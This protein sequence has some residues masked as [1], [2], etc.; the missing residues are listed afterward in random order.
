MK[1]SLLI[2]SLCLLAS[3]FYFFGPLNSNI[4]FAATRTWS[5]S[6]STDMGKSTNYSGSGPLLTTDD[7]VFNNTSVINATATST[8]DVGS[9][10]IAST[11]SGAWNNAG[12]T[13]TVEDNTGF[14]DDG[15]TG[16]HNYGNGITLNGA[17]AILHIGHGVNGTITSSNCAITMNGTTAM[18][19]DDAKNTYF[20]SLNLGASSVVAASSTA[21]FQSATIPFAIGNNSN[22]TIN[23]GQTLNI[24]RTT[25]GDLFSAGT[26]Y[27]ITSTGQLY[28]MANANNITLSMPALIVSGNGSVWLSNNGTCTGVTMQFTGTQ[29]YTTGL[30]LSLNATSQFVYNFNNQSVSVGHLIIDPWTSPTTGSTIVNYTNSHISVTAYAPNHNYA[31]TENFGSSQWT[32]SGNWTFGSNHTINASTSLVTFTNTATIHNHG[33]SF[34]DVAINDAGAGKIITLSDN[35][36]AHNLNIISAKKLNASSTVTTLGGNL[37]I[38][39]S[40]TFYHLTMSSTTARTITVATGKTLTL[41]TLAASDLNGSSGGLNIWRSGTPSSQFYLNIPNPT[42]LTYQNPQDCSVNNAINAA[43]GTSVDGLNNVNFFVDNTAPTVTAFTMPSTA[44]SL[45]VSVSSLTGHDDISV[46]GYLITSAS[47]TPLLSNP[48]WSG[49]PQSSF[50]FSGAGVQKAYAWVKDEDGNISASASST[51]SI[52]L[53][54]ANVYYSVGSTTINML[55]GSPTITIANGA[56]V[57][58]L[59]QTGNIG[60]GDKVTYNGGSIAYISG[61][62]N[63][64]EMHWNLVTATGGTPANVSTVAVAAINRTFASLSAAVTGAIGVSYLNNSSLVA[65]NAILNIPCY[66]DGKADTAYANITGYTT[67]T[68]TYIKIYTPNS[69][70]TEVNQSQR[71]AGKWDN[72]KYRLEVTD[73]SAAIDIRTNYVRIIGLQLKQIN[74]AYTGYSRT[75][76]LDSLAG[77]GGYIVVDSNIVRGQI[78]GSPSGCVGIGNA[79]STANPTFIVTNNIVYDF[80]T[81]IGTGIYTNTGIGYYYNN[82]VYNV[83]S[84]YS[85]TAAST[86]FA[87][88]NIA[89]ADTTAFTGTYAASSTNNISDLAAQPP[90]SN[91]KNL[92]IV[93]FVDAANR[94]LHLSPLDITARLSGANLSTDPYYPFTNDIDGQ[95]RPINWDAGAD[96]VGV[97]IDLT[98][99]TIN[100]FTM[101]ATASSTIVNVTSFSA[102]DVDDAVNAY[103]IT[104]SSSTPALSN[105][106]WSVTPQTS[107]T[108][109]S[110]NGVQKAYAWARDNSGNISASAS[111]TVSVTAPI[112]NVYYS[113]GSTTPNMLTGS[114]TITIT[115]G[116]AVFSIAQTGNIGV[117]DKITYNGGS[118]AYISAKT[119]SDMMH[120]NL[121]TA[122]GGTPINVS[123][124]AVTAINR[125]FASL[126][127]AIVGAKGASYLNNAS[128]VTA[129]A[130]LNI[131]CYYDGKPDTVQ[132]SVINYTTATSTYINIYTPN[133]TSTQAN[134][135][136]RHNGRWNNSAYQL[137]VKG[138]ALAI[139]DNFVRITGLQINFIATSTSYQAGIS[140]GV[141]T[142]S[143]SAGVGGQIIIDSNIIRGQITG[144]PI[145]PRGISNWGSTAN[146][147]VKISNNIIYDINTGNNDGDG[148][149]SNGNT[150][151]LYNN[152]VYNANIAYAVQ[153]AGTFYFKNDIAQNSSVTSYSFW[154]TN[155]V[156]ASSIDN[157][158]DKA[159]QAPG[160]S[161]KNLATV[162]FV[163]AANKDFHLLS[164]DTVAR[165]S[166]INLS[167]DPDYAFTNDINGLTRP[168]TWDIGADQYV[169]SVPPT[170]TAFTMPATSS[171]LTINVNSFTASDDIGVVGYLIT[172]SSPTPSVTDSHWTVTRPATFTFTGGDGAKTAYAWAKDASGNISTSWSQSVT[173]TIDNTPPIIDYFTLPATSASTTVSIS[174]LSAHD[175]VGVISYLVT[176]YSYTPT[177]T[178]TNWSV[179]IPSTITFSGNG[180]KYAY[181]WVKDANNNIS[182]G[183]QAQVTINGPTATGTPTGIANNIYYVSSISTSTNWIAARNI[184]TPCTPTTAFAN[185]QAG[186]TVYFRGGFYGKPS[187]MANYNNFTNSGTA[188]AP[189]TYTAYPGEK[190]TII[191][192][193]YIN[194]V[195]WINFSGFTMFGSHPIPLTW[196]DMPYT[197]IDDP[198]VGDTNPFESWTT[199]G[200]KVTQKYSTYMNWFNGFTNHWDN[201][202]IV[203][204]SNNITISNNNLSSF[205]MGISMAG[206]S[207]N[208]NIENNYI[209]HC[210]SAISSWS[211]TPYKSFTFENS[212]ISG[213]HVSQILN[214][215]IS[216]RYG[217]KNILI[218]NNLADYN[219]INGIESDKNSQNVTIRNNVIK[220][221]GYYS[222]TMPSPGSSGISV[223]FGTENMIIEN[224]ISAYQ[225]DPTGVD[226]NGIIIDT[227][228]GTSSGVITVRNNLVYNNLR[229]IQITRSS[230][231]VLTNNT[232][233]NNNEGIGLGSQSQNPVANNTIANNILYN[234]RVYNAYFNTPLSS[235]AYIDNNLYYSSSSVPDVYEYV[236][237][238]KTYTTLAALRA[239]TG[240]ELHGLQADPLFVNPAANDFHLTWNSPAIGTATTTY[241]HLSDYDGNNIYGAPGIGAY[242][243]Q[244]P[245]TM[246]IDKVDIGAGAKIF[247]DGK[248][249]NATT[250]SSNLADLAITPG[251][252]SFSV[253]AS[254]TTIP[255]WLDISNI[256][257]WNKTG[258]Y[259]KHWTESSSII[260]D[261]PTIHTV[262]DLSPNTNYL[263]QVDS[264]TSTISCPNG[265]CRSNS[266]GKITFTYTGGYSTHQFD[267]SEGGDNTAPVV[268]QFTIL[269]TSNSLTVPIT[270][271][272]ATDNIGVV[273]YLVNESS[274]TPDI[275]D[276]HWSISTSSTYTFA[277]AGSKILYAWA[278][279]AGSNI[280][281]S[282]T[283]SVVITLPVVNNN[284]GSGGYT[285]TI[286]PGIPTNFVAATS[287]G[288]IILSWTNPTDNDLA[289]VKLYRK[290]NSA[291]TG[292]TDALAKLIYQGKNQI[293]TDATT[294]PGALYYYSLY[295]YDARPNYSLPNTIFVYLAA[296]PVIPTSTPLIIPPLS[297]TTTVNINPVVGSS[298]A[299]ITSLIGASS[300]TVN[301]VTATEAANLV[302]NA[303]MVVF[304]PAEK[305]NYLKLTA[306]AITPLSANEKMT[307]ADFI[308]SGTPTTLKLGAG[309][310]AGVISSFQSAFNRLPTS[311]L[312]WQ[313]VIKIGN[314]R[315][316]TQRSAIAEAKAKVN[317]KKIYLRQPNLANA[318]DSSAIAIMAYGLRPAQRN[319]AS[320]IAAAKSF[321]FA[322]HRAPTTAREW[323]IVR[324]IA[325]SGAKR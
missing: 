59:A 79:G 260:G 219:A 83:Y 211:A 322:Y 241:A 252:G 182:S 110:N 186:D 243:F 184:N 196:V 247:G 180:L 269:A 108:F 73:V 261:N 137:N 264:A 215:A 275:N 309:E 173:I 319:L 19:L 238:A 271:F 230:N 162:N 285:D 134:Q 308:H 172:Q 174:S 253:Y 245:N 291:P 129:N 86:V 112:L 297:A 223:G 92:A 306:L 44:S 284:T 148:F 176:E 41:T 278:K 178:N 187:A 170:I 97:G 166:G 312:D 65:A 36:T 66:Y 228:I 229:G 262:G 30:Y 4:A 251:S 302:Q 177:A 224:N 256:T 141:V 305:I 190:P 214:A 259:H 16:A 104:Q 132:A 210:Y 168:A 20:K 96:Q 82:T 318:H 193:V 175:N 48:N 157:I 287:T 51:V 151:Y 101:P 6:A 263:V 98:A 159:N 124:V 273:G 71:A 300:A 192:Y 109:S 125:T 207:K 56:A 267:I 280:S 105:L 153:T 114:P 123:T 39:T 290:T 160:T 233:A 68:S 216:V 78:S 7:L 126:N 70:S 248:F 150:T 204:G 33:Q 14:S 220:Y 115:N 89:Q 88:N 191:G 111:S 103:L 146:P 43:D 222:E 76:R 198:S 135:S 90:G 213:N 154:P 325:Y 301:E 32:D 265:I 235:Q 127:A 107:F 232:C 27:T 156:D 25:T 188:N 321:R 227:N 61:K 34:H 163:D 311:N 128:L 258:D 316:P 158:S 58:S 21:T 268:A 1:K 5:S 293:F 286:P 87:K 24:V 236:S 155:I 11:Y 17:S 144:S 194:G 147:V 203:T 31:T 303:Q 277:S 221:S 26:G 22:L 64:D 50:T 189:I 212:V 35:L 91:G 63:A 208:L 143:C 296:T 324:A 54:I 140:I 197:V 46:T 315:W 23:S 281:A 119:N 72:N 266:L 94:D 49:T 113:V 313:D 183:Y 40:T 272:S 282:A 80:P 15:I 37:T 276:S 2:F 270:S 294:T 169:D 10:T 171:S 257:V 254:T 250:P 81:S 195:N 8:I 75:I 133:S 317:F 181:A 42:T 95:T 149:Q 53:P 299:I 199:R 57:F 218:E 84:A 209:H 47:S 304:T 289:G 237:S 29:S 28:F 99:P 307:I 295:T 145:N 202:I 239:A 77:A 161:A 255:E 13:L 152:T 131:P 116:A 240:R 234:N 231:N 18:I 9:I 69:T 274:L 320:E 52:T 226:G 122:T 167:A 217:V 130:I 93:L 60:V 225:V 139:K 74:V 279:D 106:N 117:G 102:T 164:S 136:Q 62:T 165:G 55:T 185:A 118:I 323:D 283:S 292:Q 288:K 201:G 244:P 200:P 100:S 38:A 242:E 246:S 179:S 298:T 314:G 142:G 138:T 205:S 310:R 249:E 121:V 206:D 85:K 45:T 12:Q 67:A 120:W 3:I